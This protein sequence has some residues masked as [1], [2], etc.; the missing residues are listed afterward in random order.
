[1]KTQINGKYLPLLRRFIK[2]FKSFPMQIRDQKIAKENRIDFL[3]TKKSN[4]L[5]V[6]YDELGNAFCL[7]ADGFCRQLERQEENTNY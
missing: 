3:R 4:H 7:C 6:A 5:A 2:D 1:M